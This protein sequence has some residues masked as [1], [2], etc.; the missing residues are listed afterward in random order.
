MVRRTVIMGA[1]GRDFHDF[2]VCFREDP[3]RE[4]VGFTRAETQNVGELDE[5]PDRVYPS[6]LAG[7]NY[8]EGIPI[9][10]ESDLESV[11]RE[12]DVDEVVLS[13]SDLSHETVMQQASR[14]LAAGAD[15]RLI[16]TDMM[17]NASVPVVAVDAVR[18]GCGKSGVSRRLADILND[19]TDVVVVREPMPYGELSSAVNRFETKADLDN[20]GVTIEER[21]EYEHHIEAGHVVL[22]GVDYQAV[23][24]RAEA[25]ADIIMWDGGNNELP[26]F[27]PDLHIVLADPLRAGHEIRYHPGETNLRLADYVLINKE[28]S[29]SESEIQTVEENVRDRNPEAGIIH[30][31]SVIRVSNPDEIRDQRV[32]AVEDGPTVTHGEASEGAASIAARQHDAGEIVDPS[33]FAVGSIGA[34]FDSYPHLGP[35]LPAMGYSPEQIGELEATIAAADVDLVV[36]GTPID[37]ERIVDVDVPILRVQYEVSELGEPT[38]ESIVEANADLLGL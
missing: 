3:D 6:H 36:A 23:L 28:N 1:A 2:N 37:L 10:R 31:E 14:A 21:E 7:V 9:H 19:E 15:F 33:P 25:E 17:L 26:F 12:K 11:V 22:S 24:D 13:Y 16:G 4:V 34:V 29:A 20:A 30:A 38:L 5:S 35:V 8:P 27:D 18:T 32:L